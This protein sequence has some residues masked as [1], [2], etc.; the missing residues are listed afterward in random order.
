M[1]ED[2]G[3]KIKAKAAVLVDRVMEWSLYAMLFTLPFSKSMV[4]ILFVLALGAWLVKRPLGYKRGDSLLKAFNPAGTKLNIPIA[5]LLIV[6]FLSTLTSV[7]FQ[8]SL[9]GFIFKLFEWVMIYFMVVESVS[10][11][12]KLN[13]ILIVIFFSMVLISVNGIF[14]FITG[15]DFLRQYPSEEHVIRGS[16]DNRNDFAGWLVAMIPVAL[17]LA[18]FWNNDWLDLPGSFSRARKVVKPFLW[19]LT[20]LLMICLVLTYSRGAWIAVVLSILFIGIYRNRKLLVIM[21]VI[22][23]L[24]P[25]AA[26]KSVKE[27]V[28]QFFEFGD[29][30]ISTRVRLWK[31][32]SNVIADH[33]LL[34]CGLNT[35]AI[36]GPEYKTSGEEPDLYPHNSYLHMAAETGLLGL[37]M[38]IWL[39]FMLFR[40]SLANLKKI[41]D[42][43]YGAFLTGLLAGL[44][45]FLLHSF[46]DTNIYSLQLGTLMWFVIGLIIAVQRIAMRVG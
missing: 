32:A 23:L 22:L 7:S 34:G 17:S 24:L 42:G 31:D 12:R 44:F 25:F 37:G 2:K 6:G 46:V 8:L 45:G 36:V 40:V 10:S 16:F 33:P 35:Y 4:E 41:K 5:G 13:K 38:F 1:I 21:L 29:T 11:E 20:G 26:P 15:V 30:T 43:I 3:K 28:G 18:Y 9:K 14:Q 39:I 19:G 27:R